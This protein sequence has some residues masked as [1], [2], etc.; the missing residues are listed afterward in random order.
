MRLPDRIIRN[1]DFSMDETACWEWVGQRSYS[2]YGQAKLTLAGM[3]RV[4]LAHRWLYE[5][6][7]GPIPAGL[8][9]DHLCKNKSCVNPKHLE[10]VTI[11]DNIRRG[12]SKSAVSRRTGRCTKGHH[13]V[14]PGG[15]IEY[16]DGARRACR[17]CKNASVRKWRATKPDDWRAAQSARAK[18]NRL[19]RL[20]RAIGGKA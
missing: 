13:V 3:E 15:W 2:G 6:L 8:T 18:A 10:P 7:V 5:A 14:D 17:I 9:L 20:A 16:S 19:R 12:D 11:A 4:V 1:I